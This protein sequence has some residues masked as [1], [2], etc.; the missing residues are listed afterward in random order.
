MLAFV[1]L[2]EYRWYGFGSRYRQPE[3]LDQAYAAAERAKQLDRDAALSLTAYAA[4]Q[5]LRGE[6]GE[7]EAAQRRAIALNPNNPESLVQLGFRMAFT[8]DW[9]QGMTLVRQSIERSRAPDGWYYILLA[10]DD[11]RRGDYR[12]ALADVARVGGTFFFV[13]P[14]LVAMCQAQLGN[15]E[16]AREA[17]DRAIALDPTFAKDPRGAFRLHRVPEDLIDQFMAG[18]RKAGLE[19]PE[20]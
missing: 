14:A 6:L 12:Q 3:A 2:D 7:A 20:A 18:L 1:Y 4:V 16:A 10:I 15:P 8:R 5:F 17:L 9:D 11:Y 13:S 19:I